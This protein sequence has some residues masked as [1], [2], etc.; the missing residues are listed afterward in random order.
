MSSLCKGIARPFRIMEGYSAFQRQ[1][2]TTVRAFEKV[3]SCLFEA[4][5]L[6]FSITSMRCVIV[7]WHAATLLPTLNIDLMLSI[8]MNMTYNMLRGLG[9]QNLGCC[10][11]TP[12][13]KAWVLFEYARFPKKLGAMRASKQLQQLAL[14]WR[15]ETLL[16]PSVISCPCSRHVRL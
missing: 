6:H 2:H 9:P 11:N 16:S 1:H 3:R 15:L 8:L 4:T 7:I 14:A 13:P 12:G 10:F 5:L